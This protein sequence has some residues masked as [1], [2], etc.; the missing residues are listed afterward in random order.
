[1]FL[2]F[3]LSSVG[4]FL[5]L[6]PFLSLMELIKIIWM[7]CLIFWIINIQQCLTWLIITNAIKINHEKRWL[8]P[9][10]INK[11]LIFFK[12]IFSQ[13]FMIM[14]PTTW[15]RWLVNFVIWQV[16]PF[17]LLLKTINTYKKFKM[18][19]WFK[20]IFNGCEHYSCFRFVFSKV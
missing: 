18:T 19:H 2:S 20:E 16:W 7:L 5:F 14:Q 17:W 12:K 1:M 10:L 15:K 4:S 8:W 3:L 6:C 11:W 13:F 9:I